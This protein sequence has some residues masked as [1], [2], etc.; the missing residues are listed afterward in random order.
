MDTKEIIQAAKA[1]FKHQ[2]NKLYL[3]E[4]YTNKLTFSAQGGL[5][6]AS[7]K[8]LSLLQCIKNKQDTAILIDNYNNPVKINVSELEVKVLDTYNSIMEEWYAE[9]KKLQKNR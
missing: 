7:L 9:F 6:T 8:L 3:Q 5:W 2:E 4:K 1:K